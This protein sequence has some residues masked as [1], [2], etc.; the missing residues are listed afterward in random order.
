MGRRAARGRV[1]RGAGG[2]AILLGAVDDATNIDA[3]KSDSALPKARRE[4]CVS[5][6]RGQGR[7]CRVATKERNMAL[8]EHI[9]RAERLESAGQWRRAAQ[10][11][12]IVYDQTRCETERAVICHR[13]NDCVRRS[14]ERP[15][16]AGRTR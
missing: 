10:Q 16:P 6:L 15:A 3:G 5:P 8:T 4:Q 11:W 7:E 1:N 14:R 13:R 12:L 2:R 9:Q